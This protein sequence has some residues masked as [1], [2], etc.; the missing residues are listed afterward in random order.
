MMELTTERENRDQERENL[1]IRLT[2]LKDIPTTLKRH[3][4]GNTGDDNIDDVIFCDDC[5]KSYHGDCPVHG[6]LTALDESR[7]WDQDSKSFTSVPVP[8]QVTV[9]MSS[10]MNAGKGVFAK[11]FIPRRTRI[12]P[13][14]GEVV[15]KEDVTDET[16]T[17]Y[18]FEV[19]KSGEFYYI[20]AKNEEHASW[21]RFINCARNEEEQNLLS[22]QYQGNIYCYTIKD[23][24]PG[25]ELLVWYGEQYV[26]L[27][28][29]TVDYMFDAN[30]TCAHCQAEFVE[31]YSFDIH[32]KYSQACCD[33]NPQVFKCGKCGEVFTTLINLQQHIRRH[34]QNKRNHPTSTFSRSHEVTYSLKSEILLPA[35]DSEH[36]QCEFCG[37]CFIQN[38]DLQSHL[39]I[40]REGYTSE[41]KYCSKIIAEQDSLESNIEALTEEERPHQCQQCS[42]LFKDKYK[43]KRHLLIHTGKKPYQCQHCDKS[44]RDKPDLKRHLLTHSKVKA[45]QCTH[46]DKTFTRSD[47]FQR[48]LLIHSGKC[49]TPHQCAH[50]IKAFSY[51]CTHCDKTFTRSDSLQRHLLI[52]SGKR[53]TPHQCAHCIKAF[54]TKSKL[55]AHLRTHSGERPYQ[56]E[57]C[58]KAYF[59]P[60]N[61]R[62][63]LNTHAPGEKSH[64]CEH[65]SKTFN[66]LSH[67][68]RH[69]RTHTGEKP[70]HCE[71]CDISFTVS[72]SLRRHLKTHKGEKPYQCQYCSKAFTRSN[73][74]QRHLKSHTG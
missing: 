51:Q 71:H 20:D 40:H 4:S 68:Q 38:E 28:G 3:H 63:H 61:L 52:H 46:C 39:E 74:L 72:D 67:F 1:S 62:R 47:S 22:F 8:L 69:L 65:C 55:N 24:L 66:D 11:E 64:N 12:G 7:G 45:Y 59:H 25:T 34:E 33:A 18:F 2:P 31:K 23:I 41:G 58:S 6:P 44:F 54:S 9:K 48:H 53:E 60:N 10:I 70:Y 35:G 21:L 19:K 29:L 14:K 13:Y 27:L 15:Q 26:K 32:L 73:R 43:L 30:Y 42:K 57:Y 37:E 17:S 36:F 16:D 50:C 5:D 49:E 56:C